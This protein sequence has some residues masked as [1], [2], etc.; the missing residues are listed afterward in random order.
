[1]NTN[2]LTWLTVASQ[3][4]LCVTFAMAA[5]SKTAKVGA[6]ADFR[7]SLPR[8][9]PVP[10][11]WVPAVA[12]AVV[13]A[14]VTIAVAVVVPVLMVAAFL[15]AALMMAVFTG[16]I[17]TMIRRGSVEPCHCFGVSS[18]PPTRIDVVR[19]LALFGLAVLG[20]V[21]SVASPGPT[22]LPLAAVALCA[23][24]GGVLALLVVNLAEIA[25]LWKPTSS[26][27]S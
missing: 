23:V 24:A 14:E 19:N 15:L 2:W 6:F 27:S 12:S 9:L 3:G 8:M 16:A 5:G 26:A 20:L 11:R 17:V 7:D 22:G 1:M 10:R 21:G 25:D 13:L 4:A 18:R